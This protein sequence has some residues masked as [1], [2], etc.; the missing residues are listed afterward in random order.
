MSK[1]TVRYFVSYTRDD[2]KLPEKLLTEL[3]KKLGADAG[4]D[5]IPWRDTDILV[6]TD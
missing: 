1:R 3:R 4:Y 2:K 6:G 5:F